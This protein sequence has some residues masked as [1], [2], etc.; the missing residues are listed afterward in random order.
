MPVVVITCAAPTVAAPRSRLNSLPP[1]S[2]LAPPPV[3]DRAV[4]EVRPVMVI[5]CPM[6]VVAE[7]AVR[8]KR[9]VPA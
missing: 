9:P 6:P 2:K 1:A 8:V 5:D 4:P 3:T 7:L